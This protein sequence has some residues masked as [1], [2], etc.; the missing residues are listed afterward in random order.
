MNVMSTGC[1]TSKDG[2]VLRR[3]KDGSR[4]EV[5]CPVAVVEYNK[6]MGGVDRG[7]QLRGYY[8]CNFK[9]RKFYK[10]IGH[11][12]FGVAVTNSYILYHMNNPGK[13]HNIKSFREKLALQ[14]TEDY[15]SRQKAGRFGGHYLPRLAIRHFPRKFENVTGSWKKRGKCSLCLK[16]RK[17]HDTPWFCMECR[18]WLCHTGETED[19]FLLWHSHSETEP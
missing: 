3:Q 13:K 5:S 10:Y 15:C 6:Y 2:T 17:R 19:C 11:F 16:N 12:L 8:Q 9:S 7:D 4:T 14:L 18:V 1:N